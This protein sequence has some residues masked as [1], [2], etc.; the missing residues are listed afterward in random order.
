MPA[1]VPRE[2]LFTFQLRS[3]YLTYGQGTQGA[4]EY[5]DFPVRLSMPSP[6]ERCQPGDALELRDADDHVIPSVIR[7]LL[8]WADGSVRAWEVCFPANLQCKASAQYAIGRATGTPARVT[9]QP[10]QAPVEFTLYLTLEDGAVL[11]ATVNFPELP[12]SGGT[13]AVYEDKQPFDLR[14]AGEVG[15]FTGMLIRT[16]WSW[17]P[18]V[19]L[20]VRL[21]NRMPAESVT[22]RD[23]R[24]EF[25]LPGQG[26]CRYVAKHAAALAT[27]RF[28]VESTSPFTVRA[29]AG[30]IHVSDLAQFGEMQTDYP[31]YERGAYVEST[32]S[33]LGMADEAAGWVLYVP[34][35]SER[36]P[37]GWKIEGRHVTVEVHPAWAE[38]LHW[39]QAMT[40]FQRF[41]LSR[42]PQDASADELEN[43]GL[44]WWRQPIVE[45]PAEAYRAAG[46]RIPFAYDPKRYPKT[47]YD[48]RRT[49]NFGWSSGT[50]DYGDDYLKGKGTRNHEYDFIA[51]A[52]K[53]YARTGHLEIFKLA[54]A[55]AEH[56]MYVDFVPYS[57]DP[58]KEGG[59]PAHC[60]YHNTGAAYPSHMWVEGLLLYHLMTG[61]RYA[62]HVAMR[63]GDFFLKYIAERFQVVEGTARE[64]GWTLVA[65]GALYDITHE[66]RYLAGAK[67][68]VDRYLDAGPEA[69]FPGDAT[70]C[71]GVAMIGFDRLRPF[72]RGAEIERFIPAVL[73]YLMENR[74]DELG[75]FDYWFDAERGSFYWIQA[76]LPEALNIGYRLTGDARY[77][78][79]AWRLYMIHQ[80]GGV[81]TVE[82][83]L[84]PSESGIAGGY[85]IAWTMGCLASFAERGWLDQVQYPEPIDVKV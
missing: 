84:R 22:I 82:D 6:A 57:A 60:A 3:N 39:L 18:G 21:T 31:T 35:A 81:L 28:T 42:L 5:C 73:D 36:M 12:A 13:A 76:H 61:D 64:T 10:L 53:E 50:F 69:F 40:L 4:T 75:I 77:L 16:A 54:K 15:S 49:W 23:M 41:E 26:A 56:M 67:K 79:A 71:I 52:L 59:V 38:P 33:W 8:C 83:W 14:K 80:G 34:E 30:G 45:I 55:A 25:E 29:D 66:E 62:L 65:L 44:R 37:K 17:Y 24:V 51:C 7:P 47:E 27:G 78:K 46:W 2:T 68:V 43:E 85:H 48:I 1:A 11:R 32:E 74:C 19:E 58:W 63:V 20:A 72:Y 70:F 9:E